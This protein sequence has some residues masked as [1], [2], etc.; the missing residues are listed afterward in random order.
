MA[1]TV[2]RGVI[3][4]LIVVCAMGGGTAA[5]YETYKS[6]C[7]DCHGSF[8]SGLSR[9]GQTIR[10]DS[11]HDMHRLGNGGMQTTCQLCHIASNPDEGEV[12]IGRSLGTANNSGLGCTGCHSAPGLRAHH[13]NSG[14]SSCANCH[15]NDPA[16]DPENVARP[17][18]GTADTLVDGPC[19]ADATESLNENW[20]V[21]DFIGLDNDG[22]GLYDADDPD[23]DNQGP[24]QAP[25]A[26]AGADGT[27]VDRD[28]NDAEDVLLDGSGSSDGDGEIVSYVWR[29]DGQVIAEGATP[30]VSLGIG[31]HEI[32]L[33]VT[34]EDSLTDTDRVQVRVFARPVNVATAIR[35][36]N[37]NSSADFAMALLDENAGRFFAYLRDGADGTAIRQIGLGTAELRLMATLRDISGNGRDEL[38]VLGINDKGAVL[39][40]LFDTG[41]RKLLSKFNFRKGLEPFALLALNDRLGGLGGRAVALV[42]TGGDGSVTAQVKDALT[43][44]KISEMGFGA[45]Y[46][47]LAAGAI[48]DINGNSVEELVVIGVHADG[49]V[50]AEVLDALTG[51]QAARHFFD[52]SF[53]PVLAAII[54][55]IN[56]N[57]TDD[58][59]VLG[60]NDAGKVRAEV[61]D[62]KTGARLARVSFDSDYSPLAMTYVDHPDGGALGVLGEN[63]L[64]KRRIRTK[65]L[66]NVATVGLVSFPAAVAA[67]N[68]LSLDDTDGSGVPELLQVGETAAGTVRAIAKDAASGNELYKI[69]LP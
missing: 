28:N 68:L 56:N 5:A 66:R 4:A 11:K 47:P 51:E 46:A 64:G 41:N 33:T 3:G 57:P 13:A 9:R 44:S 17:Y 53:P 55:S 24:P 1:R 37:G 15:R 60:I 59:V 19:N 42:Q 32:E 39:L 14:I 58:L 22:D 65:L 10:F 20:T 26:D 40:R 29:E 25:V 34:D 12:F 23:C 16:P 49:R 62:S 63:A 43:G 27:A 36:A 31:L 48:R 69:T 67:D 6:G 61:L 18:Y 8:D 21:G 50:R 30:T 52:D 54:P 35:D 38:A 2:L 7:D 45:A